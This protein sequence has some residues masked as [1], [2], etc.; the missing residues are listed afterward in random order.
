MEYNISSINQLNINK[1]KSRIIDIQDGKIESQNTCTT[2]AVLELRVK[3]SQLRNTEAHTSGLELK[4][5]ELKILEL[6]LKINKCK[7]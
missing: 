2:S 5:L 3:E 6:K 1:L 4:M 7:S